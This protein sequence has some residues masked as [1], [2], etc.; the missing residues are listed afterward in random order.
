MGTDIE[1]L[2]IGGCYMAKADQN[3]ALREAYKDNFE[4]D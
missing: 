1:T 3:P 4:L 2:A